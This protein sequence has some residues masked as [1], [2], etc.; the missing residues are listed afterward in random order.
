M[1]RVAF[2]FRPELKIQAVHR[3]PRLLKIWEAEAGVSRVGKES[4]WQLDCRAISKSDP[5]LFRVWN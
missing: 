2:Y 1:C 3:R 5:L 4:V